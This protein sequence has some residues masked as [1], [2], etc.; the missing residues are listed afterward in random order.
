MHRSVFPQES[1]A[2]EL[3]LLQRAQSDYASHDFPDALVLV[4]EHARRFPN[5]R[6]AEERDALRVRSL[7]NMGRG[8]EAR[9]ALADFAKHFPHSALLPRLRQSAHASEDYFP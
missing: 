7:A 3:G 4:G 2:A 5:G 9:H 6:M 1:Y 8:D